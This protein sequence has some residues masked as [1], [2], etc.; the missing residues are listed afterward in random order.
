VK[1][2]YKNGDSFVIAQREFQREFGIHRSR[3]VP[4]AHAIMTWVRN[5]EATGSTQKKKDGG[6]KSIESWLQ[7][8]RV[9]QSSDAQNGVESFNGVSHYRHVLGCTY[10][11]YTKTFL[12]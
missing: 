11:F 8:A 12:P 4:S 10:C 9:T 3:A 1:A 7:R 2:F 6:V 5:L